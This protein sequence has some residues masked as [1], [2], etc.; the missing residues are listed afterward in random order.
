MNSTIKEIQ[1]SVQELRDHIKAGEALERLR[2]NSDFHLVV[3]HGYLEEEAIRLVHS[4]SDMS[5][6]GLAEANLRD[7]EAISSFRDFL[8]NLARRAEQA[9]GALE[10]YERDL[11]EAEA[12][13]E[14]AGE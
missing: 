1:V 13:A 10:I 11:L 9:K 12:E 6:Q 3:S 8:M 5:N 4:R 2:R 14:E 7:I